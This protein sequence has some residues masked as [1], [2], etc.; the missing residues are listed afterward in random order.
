LQSSQEVRG[1]YK[2]LFEGDGESDS[3]GEHW[4]WLA[5]IHVLSEGNP[6]LKDKLVQMKAIEFLNHWA[7]TVD[8]NKKQLKEM[9]Q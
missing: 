1:K 7:I 8:Y 5:V 6:I 4:G 3:F 9:K 2:S